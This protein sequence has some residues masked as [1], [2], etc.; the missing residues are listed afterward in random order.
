MQAARAF[1]ESASSLEAEEMA[2]GQITLGLLP[3]D[4]EVQQQGSCLQALQELQDYGLQLLPAAYNQVCPLRS[5]L[6]YLCDTASL[7][8]KFSATLH[9][10]L[11]ALV[12]SVKREFWVASWVVALAYLS[13]AVWW[14]RELAQRT[15]QTGLKKTAGCGCVSLAAQH[16]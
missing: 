14:D 15:K 6:C 10:L 7:H 8:G 1:F 4:L 5:Y 13:S 12:G 2:L 3:D 9:H 11:Y 16:P